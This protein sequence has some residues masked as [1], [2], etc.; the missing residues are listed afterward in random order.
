MDVTHPESLITHVR[1][2]WQNPNWTQ[3]QGDM[4]VHC[5]LVQP[6]FP[7]PPK[8]IN[9]KG[10]LP[11]G[12]LKIAAWLR[13]EGHSVELVRGEVTC[14]TTPDEVYITSL[15][16]YW[17]EA[18]WRSVQ[19]YKEHYPQAS[20]IVGGIYASLAPDHCR[21]SGCDEVF[22]GVHAQAERHAPAYDLV[23]T[24]FQ[25]VHASRG[26]VRK[27]SFCGTYRIEPKYTYKK[28]V[29]AEIVRPHL[30]FYD[31]N[32]LANPHIHNLLNE[33]ASARHEG[34]RVT[35]ECQSGFDGRLLTP[36]IARLLKAAR[37]RNP[38]F[39]WDGGFDEADSIKAQLDMLC[40]AGYHPRDISVFMIFNY[41]LSPA[42]MISKARQCFDWGVQVADCRY[43]PLDRFTDGYQPMRKRQ[44]DSEYYVH[45]GW[46]DADVR[47]FRRLVRENN[48]CL[49]YGIDREKYDKR[50]EG[51]TRE[52]RVRLCQELGLPID[53]PLLTDELDRLN[54]AWLASLGSDAA[55]VS[56]A[57]E[58]SSPLSLAADLSQ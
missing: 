28:S 41:E 1:R 39:A 4:S 23:N 35:C 49:R 53:R 30:V 5:L 7:I 51:L 33:L 9:H 38:R 16:T 19:F 10:F 8:S 3:T 36:E 32:L 18:V 11:V 15:F 37:F 40:D 46:S 2:L 31:N 12:L 24:D 6:K 34:R 55:F 20:V 14:D 48:I 54:E 17:S 58:G 25:I 21:L 57:L 22:V 43:R 42:V 44:E 47:S 26:C 13:S 29:L 52:E 45:E 50:L 27:C 56:A